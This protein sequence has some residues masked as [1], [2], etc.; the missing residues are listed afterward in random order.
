MKHLTI[1]IWGLAIGAVVLDV[2]FSVI[3]GVSPREVAGV[4]VAIS[5]ICVMWL[6]RSVRLEFELRSRA[7]DPQLRAEHNRARERRGF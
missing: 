4:T 5:A 3:A 1:G 6:V 2:F 7:G